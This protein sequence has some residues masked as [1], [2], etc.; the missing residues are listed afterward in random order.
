MFSPVNLTVF[1]QLLVWIL[2]LAIKYYLKNIYY[3]RLRILGYHNHNENVRKHVR[4]PAIA[5]GAAN[6]AILA[7]TIIFS[8]ID[9]KTLQIKDFIFHPIHGVTIIISGA[10]IAVLINNLLH[11]LRELKFRRYRNPPDVFCIDEP[12]N[13][14]TSDGLNQVTIR[15][16][17][18][19]E[20]LLENQAE[21]IYNLKLQNT[22]LRESL[23]KS[24]QNNSNQGQ[25]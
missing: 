11:F 17:S 9:P 3:R 24:L 10:S 15:S 19:L 2:T 23:H 18:Y 22:H 14:L 8:Q 5:F 6:A 13:R 20:D 4:I 21:L 25:N 1:S 12:A 7:I 16:S